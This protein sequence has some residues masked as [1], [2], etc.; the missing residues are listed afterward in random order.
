MN[1]SSLFTKKLYGKGGNNKKLPAS[2]FTSSSFVSRKDTKSDSP[3]DMNIWSSSYTGSK[4]E[5]DNNNDNDSLGKDVAPLKER[6][7]NS[8]GSSKRKDYG[9]VGTSK[10]IKKSKDLRSLLVAANNEDTEFLRKSVQENLKKTEL[11][12]LFGNHF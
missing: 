9:N 12:E 4:R 8:Y 10:D 6:N 3:N 1:V 5:S 11:N 7:E 2:S